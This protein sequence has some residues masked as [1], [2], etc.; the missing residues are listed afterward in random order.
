MKRRRG[1]EKK[2]GIAW[3][4]KGIPPVTKPKPKASKQEAEK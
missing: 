3:A 1:I 2:V 4:M